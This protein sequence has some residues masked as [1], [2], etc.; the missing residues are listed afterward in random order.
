[1]AKTGPIIIVED[2]ADDQ[3]IMGTLM[4]EMNVLNKLLFFSK[5]DDAF[6][7][8]KTTNEQP[9]I[10]ICDVNLPVVG[11][12]DFKKRI[13]NDPELR[14][15]SIPFIFLTTTIERKAVNKAYTEMTVQGFFKKSSSINEIKHLLGLII[16][17]WKNCKHPN[18][19]A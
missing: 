16:E 3:E 6:R 2:D 14:R 15:K 13:D 17:Y 7:Y 8:L 1:M 18:T 5:C 19:E 12:L 11:G 4:R 9:F 10:I